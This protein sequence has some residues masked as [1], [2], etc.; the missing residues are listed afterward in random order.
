M[1]G[2]GNFKPISTSTKIVNGRKITT[3]RI[4][5]NGQERVESL[6]INGKEQLLRL[7]NN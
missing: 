1:G 3:K 5:E 4:V 2:L 7:D 6:T